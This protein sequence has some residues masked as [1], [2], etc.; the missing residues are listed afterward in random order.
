MKMC[1]YCEHENNDFITLNTTVDY[2]NIEM[3]INRQGMFRIRHYTDE[4]QIWFSQ[5]LIIINFC[6][7]CG[8][9]FK[10]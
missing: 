7:V 9:K 1:E 2:S 5:D 4:N 6:P 3:A 10:R 8:R